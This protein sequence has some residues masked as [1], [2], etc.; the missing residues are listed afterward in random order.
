MY[1]DGLFAAGKDESVR[2]H[3][4][5]SKIPNYY[6]LFDYRGT[7]SLSA[8]FGDPNEDYG[9]LIFLLVVWVFK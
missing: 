8:I 2:L 7:T 4:K 3:M 9:L 5:Y 1:T 6:Y